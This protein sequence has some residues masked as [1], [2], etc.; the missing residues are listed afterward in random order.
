M[1]EPF[2]PYVPVDT[3]QPEF[4]FQALFW[5][6]V[7]SA[8]FGAANAYVGI[9]AGQT[10]AATIPAAVLAIG[11]F[12]VIFRGSVLE[13]NLTRTAASV[14]EALVA[15]AIF[16]IPAFLM[17]EVEGQRLWSDFRG[18]YWEATIILLV[19]GLLGVFLIIILRRPLCVESDLPFPESVAS[20]EI[21]K[22]GDKGMGGGALRYVLGAL[23]VGALL[24]LFRD[25]RG[26]AVFKEYAEGV[27]EL[28]RSVVSHFDFSK[29]PIGDVVH[30]GA[31]PYST[32]ASSPALLGIG[33]IIGPRLATINFTGGVIAW[34]VLI[35][36]VLF[37]DPDLPLRLHGETGTAGASMDVVVYSTWYNVVRPI[38]VG[39]MLM[40]AVSTLW[41]MRDSIARSVKGALVASRSSGAGPRRDRLEQDIPLKWT[42][43]AVVGLVIPITA[44]YFHFTGRLGASL[45]LALLMTGVAFFLSA[46]GGYLV[47][48]VGSSNQPVSGLTLSALM[49]SA[50][51]LVGLKVR[52]PAGMAA[53]LGVAAVV[54]C[55][56]SVAGSLIQDLKAGYLLGGTPWKMQ[57]TEILAVT[58][59]AFFLV[60]PMM[61]LH[62]A[63]LLQGGIGIG[64]K[65]LPAPQAGL[66]AAL[67]KGIVGG[68]MAWGLI[69]IGILF[70]ISLIMIEAPS[71][72]L[73][74]VGMYLPLETTSAIFAGGVMA[75]LAQK[76]SG[77][78]PLTAEQAQ[79]A[80]QR[81]VL[82]ASGFIAGEAILGIL[83]ALLFVLTRQSVG[84]LLGL[85]PAALA[86]RWGGPL[87]VL[88]FATVAYGLIAVP[89]RAQKQP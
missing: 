69:G 14:G 48:L 65:E 35:P 12:K 17:I 49:L 50:V 72:M 20:A 68:Q 18:H 43:L 11:L 60:F 22:A 6:I 53:A 64:D 13:Q 70:G 7:L 86:K 27:W 29:A 63:N 59:L 4:T 62:E 9:R 56:C 55:A 5:G 81:G 19:G 58:T 2:K 34:W 15:G 88:V 47:G 10:I 76:L 78:R 37:V 84:E 52:G 23:G 66:M 25:S 38:A 80:Q 75:W 45:A 21:V 67:A 31:F 54:C 26:L 41:D 33:Y 39:A 89:L 40:G 51:A 28:P 16:T 79:A 73:I 3:R 44:V 74:A 1:A 83:L 71:P 61:V 46:V 24:Q 77:R 30:Q 36:L 57:L 42:V 32:P 8:L 87:S 82:I 85:G